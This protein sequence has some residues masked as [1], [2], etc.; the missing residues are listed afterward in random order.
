MGVD[1]HM[2]T[3]LHRRLPCCASVT[4][5]KYCERNISH[6]SITIYYY[7]P[8]LNYSAPKPMCPFFSLLYPQLTCPFFNLLCPPINISFLP[9]LPRRDFKPVP[10]SQ[11]HKPSREDE[12][13]RIRE[14]GGF[15][16]NNRY[17]S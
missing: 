5:T 1:T 9:C 11:D 17:V 2:L 3:Y 16:I 14:A 6:H 7:L 4:R 15:I 10:M 12:A 8:P 13:Q